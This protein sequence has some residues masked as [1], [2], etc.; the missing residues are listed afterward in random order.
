M[1]YSLSQLTTKADCDLVL[2]YIADELRVLTQRQSEFIYQ[3][4]TATKAAAELTAELTALNA[5]IDYL[6]PLIP[7]LPVSKKRKQRENDLRTSID[8]RDELVARQNERGAVGLL[9]RELELAQIEVQLTETQALETS[10]T[11]HRATL[12]N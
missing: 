12:Q 1:T 10:I 8:R 7:T 2:A 6:T 3:R 5:D 9:I 11:A 4:D